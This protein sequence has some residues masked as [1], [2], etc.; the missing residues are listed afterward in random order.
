M[1]TTATTRETNGYRYSVLITDMS[2]V[3]ERV[4][5][6]LGED[7]AAFLVTLANWPRPISIFYTGG[8][9]SP[10]YV[11]EKSSLDFQHARVLAD[12]VMKATGY[13][14]SIG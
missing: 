6:G 9:L 13:D 5:L 1:T 7:G 3:P 12:I 11:R 14:P 4:E 8:Y 10:R 2:D